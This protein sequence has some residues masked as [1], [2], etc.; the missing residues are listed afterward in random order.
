[1]TSRSRAGRSSPARGPTPVRRLTPAERSVFLAATTHFDFSSPRFQAWLRKEDLRRKKE[2]RDLDFAFR[3]ME[4]AGRTH[5]YRSELKSNRS[6]SAVAAAGWS[7][8]GGLSTLYVSILR[9]NGIPARCLTGRSIDPNTTHV[10]M[11]FYAE[12]VGWV[13]GDPAVAIGSHRAAPGSAASTST[14]SSRISTWSGSAAATSGCRGSA[15]SGRSTRAEV[16]AGS[17]FDHAMQS[18]SCRE[19]DRSPAGRRD[20][21]RARSNHGTPQRRYP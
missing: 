19:D 15:I 2:E 14:W 6:A 11:D 20:S 21:R 4:S 16:A 7:D 18:R 17:R 3:A 1:M 13:P 9:A 5:T 12:D 8:C 10:K